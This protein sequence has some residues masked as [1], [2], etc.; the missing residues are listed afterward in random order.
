MSRLIREARKPRVNTHLNA[1]LSEEQLKTANEQSKKARRRTVTGLVLRA[2]QQKAARWTGVAPK[3]GVSKS[4]T[5][6][7]MATALFGNQS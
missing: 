6:M 5:R 1:R 7:Q 4:V 2:S 3:R